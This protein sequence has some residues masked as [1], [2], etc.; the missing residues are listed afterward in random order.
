MLA[1]RRVML[2]IDQRDDHRPA[3]ETLGAVTEVPEVRLLRP[4]PQRRVSS[5]G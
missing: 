5:L 3:V 2:T 1:A 4:L